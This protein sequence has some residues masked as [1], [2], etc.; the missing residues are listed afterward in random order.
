MK[1]FHI[2]QSANGG[3]DTY[4]SAVVAA[5]TADHARHMNPG[6]FYEWSFEKQGWLFIYHDGRKEL[7]E[8][9][10]HTW[11]MPDDVTV[12]LIGEAAPGVEAGI[13]CASFNAG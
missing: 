13:I 2:S 9:G 4:D 11:A 10:D 7:E 8:S 12:K 3:Y 1:L 5:L 6:G